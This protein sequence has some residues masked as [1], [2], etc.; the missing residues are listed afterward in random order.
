M[1]GF[2]L[3]QTLFSGMPNFFSIPVSIFCIP[4]LLQALGIEQFGYLI[5]I[6]LFIN[7]SHLYFFGIDKAFINS[8]SKLNKNFVTYHFYS[9]LLLC[10]LISAF[11]LLLGLMNSW[12]GLVH[13][14]VILSQNLLF[15]LG[16]LLIH[17]IWCSE[18]VLLITLDKFSR[19]GLLNFLHLSSAIYAPTFFIYVLNWDATIQNCII[20]WTIVRSTLLI[21]PAKDLPPLKS[22][23]ALKLC[24]FKKFIFKNFT[25]GKWMGANQLLTILYESG[26]RYLLSV[27]QPISSVTLYSVPLQLSQKLAV[28]PQ[29]MATVLYP[30]ASKG[31]KLNENIIMLS[32]VMLCVCSLVFFVV[33]DKVMHFWLRDSFTPEMALISSVTFF[34]MMFASL[35]FILSG[36]IE[37][38]GLAKKSM[39]VEAF[40]IVPLIAAAI[41]L[42]KTY[43]ALG[44][45]SFLVLKEACIFLLKSR[46]TIEYF[47]NWNFVGVALG[48]SLI[49]LLAD[50]NFKI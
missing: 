12:V 14:P 30:K 48:A 16:G 9:L 39:T 15:I 40:L 23:F 29:A 33:N 13:V 4:L 36:I 19:L 5:I 46:L 10:I 26:D 35:N 2:Y 21:L 27:T 1:R 25:Y 49:G 42:I 32:A 43:G 8:S 37:G 18:R 34:A 20:S 11:M 7:Q 41:F 31:E 47:K 38:G 3:K 6:N 44:A 24:T 28:L 45:A 22:L 50:I 17:L